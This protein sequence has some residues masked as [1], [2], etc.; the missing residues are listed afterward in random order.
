MGK[1]DLLFF[2]CWLQFSKTCT[3]PF[4]DLIHNISCM[5]LLLHSQS[6]LQSPL[7]FMQTFPHPA[8]VDNKGAPLPVHRPCRESDILGLQLL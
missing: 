1:L 8:E 6:H 3:F 4:P 7:Q 2:L 5:F